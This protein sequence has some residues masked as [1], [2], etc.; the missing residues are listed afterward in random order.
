MD[1]SIRDVTQELVS[2]VY[3]I[4][5][6]D[7]SQEVVHEAKRLT[8]DSIGCGVAGLSV[9]KGK[10]AV[11]LARRLGGPPEATILGVGDKVSM[12]SASFA[13]GELINALDYD[14]ISDPPGHSIPFVISALL[15][16][17]EFSHASGRDLILATALGQEISERFAKASSKVVDSAKAGIGEGMVT[18]AL[19]GFGLC[20]IGA[21]IGI[22]KLLKFN[23]QKMGSAIGLAA[24]FTPISMFAKWMTKPPPMT[25]HKYL[26]AGW[27][28][29][30][31]VIAALLA[32]AGYN[33]DPTVLDGDV[34]Y[35]RAIGSSGWEPSV[36]LEKLGEA[37]YFPR[38][39]VY[40]PYPCCRIMHPC[41]DCF[42]KVLNEHSLMP[43]EIEDVHV[44]LSV[45]NPAW[46]NKKIT[47]H[48][49]AQFSIPYVLAVPAHRITV[50]PEWQ[51]LDTIND[52]NIT[53]FM[54]KIEIHPYPKASELALTDHP[55]KR[56]ASVVEVNTKGMKFREE[57]FFAKGD[58]VLPE[59]RM[60][61]EELINKF[62]HNTAR[63]LPL[64]KIEQAV[65]EIQELEK[66]SDIS[67]LMKELG[68]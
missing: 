5:F 55:R 8:L 18:P 52:K 48:L 15:A 19:I 64:S 63:V 43:E 17:A 12:A 49:D 40:K 4:R 61:D 65:K 24:H 7:L 51:D 23:Q 22:A 10:I 31:E 32:E 45:R 62:K 36:L 34:G 33:G 3:K 2:L 6:E 59:L 56:W 28:S 54:N 9:D 41:L 60:R 68:T 29:Q 14:P 11:Q 67:L 37:W 26:S 46:L 13:N 50:G 1:S 16:V 44:W 30:A 57:K 66:V 38:D 27:L 53:E 42:V 20:A 39:T 25:S 47:N 21:T 35:W 58:P